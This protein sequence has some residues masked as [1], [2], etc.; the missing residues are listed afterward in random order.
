MKTKVMLSMLVSFLLSALITKGQS[1]LNSK[2]KRPENI[3][4]GKKLPPPS[5]IDKWQK[6]FSGG[7]PYA[8]YQL[9]QFTSGIHD[10]EKN[11]RPWQPAQNHHP[12]SDAVDNTSFASNFHLTKDINTL[13]E[14]FPD[15]WVNNKIWE[16]QS[17]AVLNNITYFAADNGIHGRELWRS[18]GTAAGTYLVKDIN[19]GEA[20]SGP[21][22]IASANGKIYFSAFTD[23]YGQE[24]WVSDGTSAGTHLLVDINPSFN[25]SNPLQFVNVNGT[26]FF[27]AD[28]QG[29]S[30]HY[31]KRMAHRQA[32]NS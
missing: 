19:P 7:K 1:P 4:Y 16:H 8:S 11:G 26:V 17:F 28:G 5:F 23:N 6:N 14:S 31:G 12:S 32:L 25:S 29:G 9:R 2:Q 3:P 10:N 30:V 22:E 20:S 18:D 24:P 15:D 21:Y 13:S 27:A